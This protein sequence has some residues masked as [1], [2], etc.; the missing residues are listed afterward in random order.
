MAAGKKMQAS[1]IP[2]AEQL[3]EFE[4]PRPLFTSSERLMWAAGMHSRRHAEEQIHTDLT[5]VIR[6]GSPTDLAEARGKLSPFLRDTLVGLNYAYY[7]PPG[8]N[9]LHHN[10]LFVRSHDF[11]GRHHA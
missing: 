11:S 8:A 6:S 9:V 2:L 7:E 10:A 4:L 5:K 3:R 1:L